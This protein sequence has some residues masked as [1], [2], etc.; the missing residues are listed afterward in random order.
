[1]HAPTAKNL[2]TPV[3]AIHESPIFAND[4]RKF[5]G[6]GTPPLQNRMPTHP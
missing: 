5:S 2:N 6:G 1:M 4:N 3:G